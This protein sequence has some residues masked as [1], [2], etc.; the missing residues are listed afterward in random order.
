MVDRIGAMSDRLLSLVVPKARAS[1]TQCWWEY[2]QHNPCRRRRCCA[3]LG[4]PGSPSCASP[5]AC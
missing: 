5:V 4:H 1:A 3:R 2:V